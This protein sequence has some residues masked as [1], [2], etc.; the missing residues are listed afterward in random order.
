MRPPIAPLRTPPGDPLAWVVRGHLAESVH[1]GHLLVL[2]GDRVVTQAGDPDAPIFA[3]SSLKPVQ[4]VAMLRAGLVVDDRQLGLACGSHMGTPAHVE[5][6]RSVLERVGLDADALQNTPDWPI[7]GSARTAVVRAGGGPT[8]L[9]Q[10]CSGKHAAML[11]TC[12]A[13]GWDTATYRDPR[14]P[15]QRHIADVV[16]ELCGDAPLDIAIDGCGAPLFGGT[17]RG[18]ARAFTAIADGAPGSPEHRV[19][20]AMRTYP[21]MVAGE[22]RTDTVAMRDV[23]GLVVKG[24][25]EGVLAAALPGGRAVVA[26][27]ADGSA[28][29]VPVLLAAGLRALGVDGRWPWA[30]V[31]VLGHGEQVGAVV[32]AVPER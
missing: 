14:H 19:A 31:P 13:A 9:T 21:E 6:A 16:T 23:E 22:G 25:A 20:T 10:N 24:G 4:A 3:R 7:D 12:V 2:D 27:V 15:L 5:V 30:D 18:L 17:L 8:S 29:P 28:R 32:A 11:A 26:K 1:T